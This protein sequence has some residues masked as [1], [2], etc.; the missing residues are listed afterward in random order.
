MKVSPSRWPSLMGTS[1]SQVGVTMA[2]KRQ[3]SRRRTLKGAHIV[4]HEGRSTISCLVRNLSDT[5]ALL[6]VES[7]IGI[8]DTF[9]LVIPGELQREAHV[10]RRSGTEIGVGF[11]STARGRS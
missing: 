11:I 6:R 1:T 3:S 2:E 4:F 8:P 7:P 5:G 9:T 10:V